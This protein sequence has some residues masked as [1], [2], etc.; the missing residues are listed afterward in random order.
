MNADGC[1]SS[2]ISD[3]FVGALR[4]WRYRNTRTTSSPQNSTPTSPPTTAPAT[5]PLELPPLLLLFLDEPAAEKDD[6]GVVVPLIRKVGFATLVG[7][8]V[9]EVVVK[10]QLAPVNPLGH[11]HINELIPSTH[12]PPF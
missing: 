6:V 8:K 7:A 1:K 2:S 10:T 12:D 4:R 5:A 3:N 11:K 9:V